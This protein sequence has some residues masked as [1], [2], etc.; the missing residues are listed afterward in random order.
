L[1]VDSRLE[2]AF[3]GKPKGFQVPSY[4]VFTNDNPNGR[5]DFDVETRIVQRYIT[6]GCTYR[7]VEIERTDFL[8]TYGGE[9]VDADTSNQAAPFPE[10]SAG[11][12]PPHRYSAYPREGEYMVP[13]NQRLVKNTS[14][15]S[16]EYANLG[17]KL[18][19]K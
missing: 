4:K 16:H 12:V 2:I 8:S 11:P 14:G 17:K 9:S 5:V 7:D 18:L 3:K 6:P 13:T 15:I 19:M 10:Q 1:E